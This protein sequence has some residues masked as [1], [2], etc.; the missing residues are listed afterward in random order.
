MDDTTLYFAVDGIRHADLGESVIALLSTE[1]EAREVGRRLVAQ[2]PGLL[3][4]RVRRVLLSFGE[5]AEIVGRWGRDDAARG[6]SVAHA[7]SIGDPYREVYLAG[8]R[9]WGGA[10]DW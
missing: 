6:Q 3:R 10:V 5:T 7:D 8:Y 4:Y 9:A 1:D 2:R